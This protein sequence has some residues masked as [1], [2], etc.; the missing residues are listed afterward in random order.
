M[1]ELKIQNVLDNHLRPLAIDDV[2]IPIELATDKIRITENTRFSKNLTIEGDLFIEGSTGDINMTNGVAIESTSSAGFIGLKA[3]D[4]ATT[5]RSRYEKL[6]R[7][8]I[9]TKDEWVDMFQ[10]LMTHSEEINGLNDSAIRSL[11][12][13]S[14]KEL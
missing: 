5:N 11:L 7:D 6:L 2:S 1:K 10:L 4:I 14:M 3:K 9:N 8:R 13:Q 12:Q